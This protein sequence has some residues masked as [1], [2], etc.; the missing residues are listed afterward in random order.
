M[1]SL[2]LDDSRTTSRWVFRKNSMEFSVRFDYLLI[3]LY[4]WLCFTVTWSHVLPEHSMTTWPC[5]VIWLPEFP[6]YL[7]LDP[8]VWLDIRDQMFECVGNSFLSGALITVHIFC[9][10]LS[11]G[12]NTKYSC[13]FFLS[14]WPGASVPCIWKFLVVILSNICNQQVVFAGATLSSTLCLLMNHTTDVILLLFPCTLIWGL[15]CYM[16]SSLRL[17]KYVE[18]LWLLGQ[19]LVAV[20]TR[21]LVSRDSLKLKHVLRHRESK[22]LSRAAS[23]SYCP[24]HLFIWTLWSTLAEDEIYLIPTGFLPIFP[25]SWV[26]L[27]TLQESRIGTPQSQ[28]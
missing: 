3:L 18:I 27:T 12:V 4:K 7:Y 2:S 22:K 24:V 20:S 14:W 19:R 23:T 10:R 17:W 25:F 15:D 13:C 1:L 11:L 21:N 6:C 28:L 9:A 26:L 16:L 5:H 8:I